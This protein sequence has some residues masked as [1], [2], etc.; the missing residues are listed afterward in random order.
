MRPASIG[1][2]YVGVQEMAVYE[3]VSSSPPAVS[4]GSTDLALNATVTDLTGNDYINLTPTSVNNA[5]DGN[6]STAWRSGYSFLD[7]SVKL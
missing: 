4:Y 7:M 3:W 5:V 2:A 1:F 6:L